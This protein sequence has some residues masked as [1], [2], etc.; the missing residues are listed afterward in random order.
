MYS[1]FRFILRNSCMHNNIIF[2]NYDALLVEKLNT[3]RIK[4]YFLIKCLHP[5][6]NISALYKYALPYNMNIHKGRIKIIRDVNIMHY[7]T[8]NRIH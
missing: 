8:L 5:A 2:L 1:S 7:N 4:C 6:R 3:F